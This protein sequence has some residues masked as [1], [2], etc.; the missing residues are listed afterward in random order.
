MRYQGCALLVLSLLVCTGV[1]QADDQSAD[2]AELR[3]ALDG[4]KNDYQARI[5]ALEKRLA[6]AEELARSADRS[7]ENAVEIA[8]ET[9][10]AATAG[11]SAANTF[12]PAIGV[13]LVARYADVG[14][15]W[16]HIPGFIGGEELGP[17]ASG[18]TLGESEINLNANVDGFF[19]SNLTLAL[20][21]KNGETEVAVEEAWV[22]TTGLAP[23]LTLLGGRYFSGLGYLNKFHRHADDFTDRP[24]PYQAFL[25]GQY[26]A[27]GFSGRWIAPTPLFIEIGAELNWGSGFPATSNSGSS[28]GAW[29]LFTKVGGDAGFSHSWQLGLAYLSADVKERRAGSDEENPLAT[30]TFTGD[31]DLTVFDFV[32]KWSP[33][34]NPTVRNLK[35]QGEY[36]WRD[37]DGEFANL[38]Y[39]GNQDGWYL[40]GVWQFM[41]RWRLGY[42]HAEVDTDNG[43]LFAGTAL[44]D[45]VNNSRRDSFMIDWSYSEFS[46]L[47]LQYVY[48]RVLMDSDNQFF[49]Q[50]I[51]S[52]GAHG[53]HEF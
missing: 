32:W 51:M 24:L 5:N 47:R 52:I 19:F 31:S 39:K 36:F 46:R 42:R 28:A 10:I 22:Q 48:D 13:A 30:E 34:G 1:V 3:Q 44:E 17:G 26:V 11:S 14:H 20:E 29:T 8:E 27:D 2:I 4:I 38:P 43:P 18:F 41:P 53:S 35:L 9:A 25:G 16:E 40:Q 15:G 33:D 6:M 23:G 49:F 45:P 12:N 7:A 50:Y 21:D 37:E